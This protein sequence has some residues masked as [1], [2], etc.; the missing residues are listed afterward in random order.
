MKKTLLTLCVFL[1]FSLS[2]GIAGTDIENREL[3]FK[4]AVEQYG[5]KN[6]RSALEIFQVLYHSGDSS[7]ELLFNMG[8]CHYRLGDIGN[9]AL[10]WEKA[11]LL[12]PGNEDLQHNLRL[13]ELKMQDKVVLPEGFFLFE[14]YWQLRALIATQTVIWITGFLL[15][16]TVIL[17]TVPTAFWI[18]QDV[19]VR[20]RKYS[21][22]PLRFSLLLTVIF[23]IAAA[24][25]YRYNE[26]QQRAIVLPREIKVNAEPRERASVL[27]LLHAGSKVRI[28]SEADSWYQISYYDDKVGWVKAEHLGR[29]NEGR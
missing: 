2:A 17:L 23:A 1:I 19:K 25:N 18:S 4:Q 28:L 29:I 20:L 12:K 5:S 7:F 3:Q 11:A 15:L 27:F 14:W 24:D 22:I 8:N 10:Y 13:L 21:R 9:A 26:T 6:F 16:L